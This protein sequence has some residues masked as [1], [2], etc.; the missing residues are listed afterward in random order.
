ARGVVPNLDRLLATLPKLNRA[1]VLT[2]P[3]MGTWT[4]QEFFT[5]IGQTRLEKDEQGALIQKTYCRKI[6]GKA[7]LCKNGL[8]RLDLQ[9]KDN[10]DL[11]RDDLPG[12]ELQAQGTLL[13][14]DGQTGYLRTI[15]SPRI[16]RCQHRV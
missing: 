4:D 9:Y 3:K 2:S 5:E 12:V 11:I 10:A 7:A 16:E 8:I 1:Y 15:A 6:S 13:L 14:K